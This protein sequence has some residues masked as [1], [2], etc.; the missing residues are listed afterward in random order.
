V[1]GFFANS[2]PSQLPDAALYNK[3]GRAF[4]DIAAM[5]VFF[6]VV[7]DGIPFFSVSGTSCACPVAAG[8]VSLLNEQRVVGGQGNGQPLGFLNPMLYQW[9]YSSGQDS[10]FSDVTQGNNPGCGTDG[11]FAT[12][13]WDP[14]TGWGSPNYA[15]MAK[16]V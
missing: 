1:Q 13:G 15:H 6:T 9:G 14:V 2:D 3:T 8:I 12:E 5:S 4:P 7:A 16:L 10:P 11:F